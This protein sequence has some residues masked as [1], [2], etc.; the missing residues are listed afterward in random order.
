MG[1]E[2]IIWR[3]A[4]SGHGETYLDPKDVL[5]RSKRG[6][7]DDESPARIAFLRKILAYAPAEGLDSHIISSISMALSRCGMSLA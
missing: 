4:V 7:L 5:W 2:T 1:L 6:M 3:G